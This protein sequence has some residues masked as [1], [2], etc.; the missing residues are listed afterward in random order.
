MN[1]AHPRLLILFLVLVPLLGL[2]A[3]F[4]RARREKAIA[5]IAA[6]PVRSF[7]TGLQG[8]LMLI[9]LVLCGLAAARPQWGVETT[10]T[11]KSFG[12]RNVVVALD[13]SRSMLAEDVRPNRLERAKSDVADLIDSLEAKDADGKVFRD[14][15]A[16]V[17]FRADGRA[18]SPLTEDRVYLK[19]TLDAVTCDSASPGPTHLAAG[20][21][22]ALELI[23][24]AD[25]G[26]DGLAEHS[27]II[28]I[29]DGGDPAESPEAAQA[30][31]QAERAKA[32]GVPVFTIGIGNPD[33]PT[34]IRLTD[35]SDLV[36]RNQ[37]VEVKLEAETLKKIADLSGGRYVPFGTAQTAETSLGVVYR[38]FLR[39]VGAAERDGVYE[40]LG[41]RYLWFLIPGLAALIAGAALS[42][43]RFRK[44]KQRR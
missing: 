7:A 29:S 8:A 1:F 32:R 9:G 4:V 25:D 36:Y 38:E 33:K 19:Q 21:E 3:T 31:K 41:E 16:L 10:D 14:R 11:K 22:A 44:N 2:Y 40:H 35:G 27:A 12:A 18:I 15:C 34:A 42:R 43:G 5:L 20:I 6:K 28:L 23:G 24:E 26:A 37:K 17:V 39:Q 30:F 13:V